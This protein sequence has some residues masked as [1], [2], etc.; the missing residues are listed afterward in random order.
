MFSLALRSVF[1]LSLLFGLA[2]AVSMAAMAAMGASWVYALVFALALLGLQYLIGPWIIQWIHKIDWRDPQTVDPELA[3]F[4]QAICQQRGIRVPRFGIIHDGNP[5]AFTFGHYPGNARMVVTTGLLDICDDHEAQ[6][7]VAHEVGHIVHWDF[8]VMTVAAAV[9][10]VLYVI[11]QFGFRASRGRGKSAGGAAAVGLAAFIAYIVSRYI[12][13]FLSRV[14]EYYA[15]HFAADITRNPNALASAL[16]KIAYGLARAPQEREDEEGGRRP[17]LAAAGGI[18]TRSLGIFDQS[19]G[20]SLALAAAGSY[21]EAQGY[22]HDVTIQAMRWDLWNPWAFLCE[23]SSTH[24]LP[25]KR[26]KA[27]EKIAWEL[28]QQP[29]YDL[30][31]PEERPE[32]YWDEFLVDVVVGYMPLFGLLGGVIVGLGLGLTLGWS[33]ALIGIA[34][35][36]LGIGMLIR[37]R[38]AYPKRA[39][40]AKNVVDLVG[41]IKVSKIRSVPCSIRGTII[42]RGIPGLYW[43][44]DLVLRDKTGFIRLDYRQPIRLF[45]FLFGLFRAEQFIGQEV[46]VEGW[47]RRWPAP[48]VEL[49]KLRDMQ[50]GVQTSY[51]WAVGF[52]GSI[53]AIAVGLIVGIIGLLLQLGNV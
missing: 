30:P 35:L 9:P 47:Y 49:W 20:A 23:V 44:E 36:G 32:S 41:E 17:A 34:I 14:R 39:F 13:L 26:I 5:N 29:V 22:S 48:Y 31:E 10:M 52:Y 28:G 21:S 16:V 27:L 8:V 15:D 50:G 7:V 1:V 3:T 43:S 45:E 42:G 4:I 38:F 40:P 37:V 19:F 2:F 24:P 18:G 33:A 53:L 46:T 11:Y 12:V 25:A 6:T 51:N